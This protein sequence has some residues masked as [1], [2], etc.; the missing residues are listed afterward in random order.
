MQR[1]K[2]CKSVTIHTQ[3]DKKKKQILAKLYNLILCKFT[4]FFSLLFENNSAVAKSHWNVINL[5]SFVSLKI[6]PK[7]Q[8]KK[9]ETFN[10]NSLLKKSLFSRLGN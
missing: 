5:V 10:L 6:F 9:N 7:E 1:N 8:R 4:H 2:F 3:A